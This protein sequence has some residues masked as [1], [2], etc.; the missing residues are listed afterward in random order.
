MTGTEFAIRRRPSRSAQPIGGLLL[1]WL[2]GSALFPIRV[3]GNVYDIYV[4]FLGLRPQLASIGLALHLATLHAAL[5][6]AGAALDLSHICV[7]I[8]LVSSYIRRSSSTRRLMITFVALGV[9]H[10]LLTIMSPGARVTDHW[11]AVIVAS[12]LVLSLPYVQ[13]SER[14][15]TTFVRRPISRSAVRAAVAGSVVLCVALGGLTLRSYVRFD[16]AA[17]AGQH[18]WHS[19]PGQDP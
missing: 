7:W 17:V 16:P 8:L 15:R 12:L 2:I 1:L 19:A 6:L 14:V 3:I 5:F 18:G 9:A 10:C 11:D 13:L 4:P